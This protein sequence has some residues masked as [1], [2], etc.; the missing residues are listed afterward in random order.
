[1]PPPT[2]VDSRKSRT[3]R[4]RALR[5]VFGSG[6]TSSIRRGSQRRPSR[7]STVV[8]TSTTNCVNARSGAE[9]H[10]KVMQVIRPHTLTMVSVCGL[11]TCI[12]FVWF[13]APD[14]ALTQLVVEVVTTVLILLGLRWLPRRIEEVSP[15]PNT[16]RKAR[17]R[18]VRDF[19]LSTVVGGG[20][21]LL[22]YAMLTRQ[23]PNDISS[24][25]LSRALPEAAA[26]MW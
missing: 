23:T 25:Y 9:N 12:T 21:A 13:S 16:L 24:F 15:L 7:I 1:M 3:R 11:M 20:M 26:A 22:S 17:I 8:T 6:E 5:K 14:L 4:I 19:L 10:T 18:R 2:T